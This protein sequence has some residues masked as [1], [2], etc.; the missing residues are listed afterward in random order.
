MIAESLD[1]FYNDFKESQQDNAKPNKSM[2]ARENAMHMYTDWF[3]RHSAGDLA[4]RHQ[5]DLYFYQF[6]EP[7]MLKHVIEIEKI[8]GHVSVSLKLSK[9]LPKIDFEIPLNLTNLEFGENLVPYFVNAIH[10]NELRY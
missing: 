6:E 7:T 9:L 1:Y 5:N 4:K 3:F 10:C 2:Y 8:S